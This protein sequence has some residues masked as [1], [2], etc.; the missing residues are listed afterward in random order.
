MVPLTN[1][2]SLL[3][4]CMFV[5]VHVTYPLGMPQDRDLASGLLQ[6]VPDQ[7]VTASRDDKVDLLVQ[8]E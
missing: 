2:D 1:S 7:L 6:D 3:Y 8:R 4:V 5:Y